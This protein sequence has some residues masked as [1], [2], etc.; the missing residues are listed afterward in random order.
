MGNLVK[1][2]QD[3]EIPIET[4]EISTICSVAFLCNNATIKKLYCNIILSE[5]CH[6]ESPDAL[7]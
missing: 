7:F 4:K 5:N 2:V 6:P 1:R 3:T